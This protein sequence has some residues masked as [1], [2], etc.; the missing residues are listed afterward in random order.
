MADELH[1]YVEQLREQRR[2][3]SAAKPELMRRFQE[4]QHTLPAGYAVVLAASDCARA[5]SEHPLP[6]DDLIDL[7]RA[8][9]A[10][11]H[12]ASRSATM[13]SALASTGRPRASRASSR[14]W[15]PTAMAPTS[16]RW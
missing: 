1:A 6:A 7:A 10:R 5:G 2:K 3:H 13:T 11:L 8:Y 14:C 9:Y 4:A 16:S 15:S 12:P